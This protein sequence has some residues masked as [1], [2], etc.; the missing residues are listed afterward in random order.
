MAA[1]ALAIGA[2]GTFSGGATTKRMTASEAME[3]MTAAK[4]AAASQQGRQRVLRNQKK[5]TL[6]TPLRRGSFLAGLQRLA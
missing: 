5:I 3:A 1:G 4:K 2:S 6:E